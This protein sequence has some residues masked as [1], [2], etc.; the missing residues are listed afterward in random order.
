MNKQVLEVLRLI[1]QSGPITRSEISER[2]EISA[3]SVSNAI[4]RLFEEDLLISRNGLSHKGGRRPELIEFRST[5][6]YVVG[7]DLGASWIRVAVADLK[8]MILQRREYPTLA[9]EGGKK[10]AD[11]LLDI[12]R[13]LIGRSNHKV[14]AVGM[15]CPGV[16]VAGRP[17]LSPYIPELKDI[18][19]HSYIEDALG[20]PLVLENDVDMAVL[21]EM[22]YGAGV[23][24]SDVVFLN[25]GVGLAAGIITNGQLLRGNKGAAGE[26]GFM[27]Q[28]PRSTRNTFCEKGVAELTLSGFG[29]V[30][31][32]QEYIESKG[33]DQNFADA[34]SADRVFVLARM[35][36]E[37]AAQVISECKRHMSMIIA[38]V[39]AVLNPERVI[40]GGGVGLA[41][42]E[43]MDIVPFLENHIPFVPHVVAA[44]LGRDASLTGSVSVAVEL[45]EEHLMKARLS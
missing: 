20:I 31:R 36:D 21:G 16:C 39:A 25:V 45:V 13:D 5:A 41:L 19:L 26:I 29:I 32:Y 23:G 42:M 12:V 2:L 33:K 24:C 3:S 28:D 34:L 30:K 1:K 6:G 9:Y 8:G 4:N 43:E 22:R 10:I 44:Q 40:V 37:A 7:I 18:E 38:N 11:R 17:W 27:V 15:A 14:L 35:G